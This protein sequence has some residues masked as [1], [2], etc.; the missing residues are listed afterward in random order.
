[1]AATVVDDV[2]SVQT[3]VMSMATIDVESYLNFL[4]N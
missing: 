3:A 2:I 4:D 1:M